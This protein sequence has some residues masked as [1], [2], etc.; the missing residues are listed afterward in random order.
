MPPVP[1][2]KGGSITAGHG[3]IALASLPDEQAPASGGGA[4]QQLMAKC[5][6]LGQQH[7]GQRITQIM[8]LG[9]VSNHVTTPDPAQ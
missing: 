8:C 7:I 5:R 3:T 2:L 4:A 1:T 6:E 9:L